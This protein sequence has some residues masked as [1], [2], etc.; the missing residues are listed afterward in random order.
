MEHVG[1]RSS[2][3]CGDAS[4]APV[5]AR[6]QLHQHDCATLYSLWLAAAHSSSRACAGTAGT[7]ADNN[8]NCCSETVGH[9]AAAAGVH[10]QGV[11]GDTHAV[12]NIEQ[13]HGAVAAPSQRVRAWSPTL[14]L[15][16]SQQ[17]LLL[18]QQ[19]RTFTGS[20]AAAALQSDATCVSRPLTADT[21]CPVVAAPAATV[22]ASLAQCST[23]QQLDAY[24]AV[25]PPTVTAAAVTADVAAA[26]AMSWAVVPTRPA[27]A[28]TASRAGGRRGSSSAGTA[29]VSSRRHSAAATTAVAT[30]GSSSVPEQYSTADT[31]TAAAS[32]GLIAAQDSALLVASGG[33]LLAARKVSCNAT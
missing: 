33:R 19:L 21:M 24:T 14:L 25:T 16:Q 23:V 2:E 1:W 31:A 17:S 11:Q 27:T 12:P 4:T 32:E 18:Q 29:L 13:A 9:T 28:A 10:E 15:D 22:G 26:Y 5:S 7:A 8:D 6:I 30:I 20:V 3:G